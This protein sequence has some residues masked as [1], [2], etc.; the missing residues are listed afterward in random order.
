MESTT[1]SV[2]EQ[3]IDG[4]MS[5]SAFVK[6]AVILVVGGAIAGIIAAIVKLNSKDD[7]AA[8]QQYDYGYSPDYTGYD[9]SFGAGIAF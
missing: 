3:A 7:P 2:T 1:K 4:F 8:M 6:I 5:G 9:A